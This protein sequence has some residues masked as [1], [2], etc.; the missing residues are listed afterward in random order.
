VYKL[1]KY[2]MVNPLL[3]YVDVPRILKDFME[4]EY[5]VYRTVAAMVTKAMKIQAIQG[6][7]PNGLL[8]SNGLKNYD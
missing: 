6:T 8:E 1:G 7:E 5:T 3:R 4:L 2:S